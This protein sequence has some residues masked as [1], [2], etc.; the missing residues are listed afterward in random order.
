MSN[1]TDRMIPEDVDLNSLRS[2]IEADSVAINKLGLEYPSL[3]PELVDVSRHASESGFGKTA[4]VLL[5][6]TPNGAAATRDVAQELLNTTDFETI[7][8]RTPGSGA[9]V[10]HDFSRAQIE[11]AQYDF[12]ANPEIASGAREF[13]D[14]LNTQQYPW[15]YIN[16]AIAVALL[17]AILVS[18]YFARSSTHA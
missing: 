16:I 12:F 9:I 8:V 5:D 6:R 1:E 11:A 3:E 7:I 13:V 17:L 18:A 4:F 10:S 2:Q 14:T 15:M